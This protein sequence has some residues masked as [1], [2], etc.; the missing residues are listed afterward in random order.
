MKAHSVLEVGKLKG[1]SFWLKLEQNT[2][3][4]SRTAFP[5]NLR[6]LYNYNILYKTKM[7]DI[8]WIACDSPDARL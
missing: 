1:L 2:I 6:L 8:T 5:P 3:K 7:L 4:V